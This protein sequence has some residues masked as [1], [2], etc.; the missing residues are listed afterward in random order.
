MSL[1][2]M[3]EIKALRGTEQLTMDEIGLLA[4]HEEEFSRK[5]GFSRAFPLAANVD[6]Y[7]KFFECRRYCNNLLWSYIRGGTASQQLVHKHY[8]RVFNENI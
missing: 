7:E 5:G 1:E 3:L 8:K 2:Q 4:E 6:Y